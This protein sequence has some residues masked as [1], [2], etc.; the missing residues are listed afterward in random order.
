MS[1]D[2]ATQTELGTEPRTAE[3]MYKR[4]LAF[5]TGQGAPLDFVQA[6]KWFNLAALNGHGEAK[7]YRKEIADHMS[8]SEVA[9]AQRQARE[10]LKANA[11][12]RDKAA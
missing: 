7:A 8:S 5:S 3:D 11:A 1:A 4:G 6:H 12:P 2:A 10:W 9:A